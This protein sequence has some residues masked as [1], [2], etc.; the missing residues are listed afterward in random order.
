MG[1]LSSADAGQ[2][3]TSRIA[4]WSAVHRWLIL[5]ASAI[6]IVLALLSIVFVGADIR[7]DS[8]GVGESGLGAD[9]VQDRF[10]SAPA[11]PQEDG[12]TRR[13][14][15]IFSNPSLDASDPLFRDTVVAV[16]TG[17]RLTAGQITSAAAVMVGVFAAFAT[18]R[19]LG[20]QQFGLGLAVAVFIDATV[21]R[22]I[23]LPASM[24]LL[25]K[26]NWYLPAWLDWLPRVTPADAGPLGGQLEGAPVAGND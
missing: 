12:R 25:G 14:G 18:S 7:D 11:D 3:F 8:G 20:L 16:A 9:L 13:E 10:N 21:I 15:V 24:K 23:L 6:V 4:Y 22:V 1:N 17:I 19:I 26:W 2:T 5:L